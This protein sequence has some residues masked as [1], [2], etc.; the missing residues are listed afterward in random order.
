MSDLT[1]CGDT[2]SATSSPGSA[3]GAG[4]YVLPDGRM[5][6]ACGLARAL[7]SLSARQ[8]RDMGLRM[9]GI[10]GR[11]GSTSS[12][13]AAL[14]SSLESRLRV[15]LASSGSTLFT[16]TWKE[17]VTPSGRPICA[18]RASAPRTSDNASGSSGWVS[19]TAQD[20]T[21]GSLPPRPHDTGIPLSQQA[22]MASWPTPTV[23]NATGSQAAKGASA[24]GR[25][26]DGSK[27]TV[28]VNAVA[29]LSSWPTPTTRDHKDGTSEGTAPDNALLGRVVWQTRGG[30][31]RFTATGEMLTGSSAGMDGGGPLS[32][33]MSRWL[34]GYPPE[35]CA[36][37]LSVS[38]P[39]RRK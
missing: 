23:G 16:L 33:H 1:T 25:R 10:S 39:K 21:R 20:G 6:D 22:V 35:W 30:P 26:P 7:A 19:P 12:S 34:M 15:L 28:S 3:G 8:A 27:A 29:Q 18:L 37:A 13:S 36:A 11:H 9:S 5:T 31:A 24:T 32:P 2:T 38:L 4:L 17:R 14:Q